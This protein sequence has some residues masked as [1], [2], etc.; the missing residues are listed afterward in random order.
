M[1]DETTGGGTGTAGGGAATGQGS[2]TATGQG[3]QTAGAGA[4][5]TGQQ[6]Q[7]GKTYTEAELQSEVDRRTQQAL[8]TREAALK[9]QAEKERLAAEGKWKEV[10]EKAEAEKQ[11]L[12]LERETAAALQ[13]KGLS[14]LAEFV[15]GPDLATRVKQ[16]AKLQ[17]II[18]TTVEQRVSEKLK[19]SKPEGGGDSKPKAVKDMTPEEWA[20]NR[21]KL[22]IA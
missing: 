6:Q 9:A 21:A 11:A 7:S 2:Q 8:L 5:G 1:A 3:S 20:K 14:H 10:A 18:D 13:D 15:T 4:N 22:G 19:T 17:K 12:L 16:A